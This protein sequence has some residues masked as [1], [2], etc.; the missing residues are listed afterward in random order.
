M[1]PTKEDVLKV[2]AFKTSRSG[3]KGGQNVNKVSS[4]VE[5]ILN[6]KDAYFLTEDEK[7]LLLKRL[8]PRLDSDFNLH[9]VAQED[10]SQLMNKE[11]SI[12]KLISLLKSSLVVDKKR[13]NTKIP[14]TIIDKRR[15]NKKVASSKKQLRRKPQVD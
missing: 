13:V 10:R 4:K 5:L 8:R 12:V 6:I 15:E 2:A 3:G 9:I 7:K 1:I 11:R 14:K